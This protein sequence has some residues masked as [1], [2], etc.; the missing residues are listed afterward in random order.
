MSDV[1]RG[2]QIAIE[3]LHLC[4][5]K[6][7]IERSQISFREALRDECKD[8]RCLNQSSPVGYSA[9]GHALWD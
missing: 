1:Q 9:S 7:I 3:C 2:A 5:C 8:G 4:K 6:C